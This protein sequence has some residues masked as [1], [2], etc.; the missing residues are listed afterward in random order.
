MFVTLHD[1]SIFLSIK[2]RIFYLPHVAN[3]KKKKIML[4]LRRIDEDRNVWTFK[5]CWARFHSRNFSQAVLKA[6]MAAQANTAALI[7]MA[8]TYFKQ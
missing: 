3:I 4:F 5:Q 7:V 1:T 6:Q 2:V 8:G